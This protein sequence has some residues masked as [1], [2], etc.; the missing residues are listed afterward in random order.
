MNP[1]LINE[2]QRTDCNHYLRGDA[3][4][5]HRDIKN[6]A[7]QEACTGLSKRCGEVVFFALMMGDVGGPEYLPFMTQAMQPVVTEVIENERHDPRYE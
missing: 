1:E 5:K 6:P 3:H 4:Q 2:I 7:Q